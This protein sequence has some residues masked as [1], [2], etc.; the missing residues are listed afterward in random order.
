MKGTYSGSCHCGAVRFT[1]EV[2]LKTP[3]SQPWSEEARY[4]WTY[5]CNCTFCTKTRYW[6]LFVPDAAFTLVSGAEVLGDYQFG[7]GMVHHRF[8]TRCGV[9]PFGTGKLDVMGGVF[10]AL[11]IGCLDDATSA[12]LAALP[13]RYE[14]GRHDAWDREPAETAHL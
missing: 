1:A 13:V 5:K 7:E 8:C 12:E 10:H 3:P 14:D 2:N 4:A 9:A 6:K 11:N